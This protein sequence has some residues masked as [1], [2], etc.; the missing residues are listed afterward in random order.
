MSKYTYTK[1]GVLYSSDD[2]QK[3][4][5]SLVTAAEARAAVSEV[6]ALGNLGATP[7][8]SFASVGK[9]TGTVS[10]NITDWSGISL[11]AGGE[12]TLRLDNSGGYTVAETGLTAGVAGGLLAI[13]EASVDLTLYTYDGSTIYAVATEVA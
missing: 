9:Y 1:D 13:A 2:V 12:V 5:T 3:G 6:T 4:G 11:A 7:D 10:A 8:T